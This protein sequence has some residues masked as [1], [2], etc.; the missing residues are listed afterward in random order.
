LE[1]EDGKIVIG[2]KSSDPTVWLDRLATIFRYIRYV[3]VTLTSSGSSPLRNW[4]CNAPKSL[5]SSRLPNAHP[6]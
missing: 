5:W 4:G 3:T 1:T 6:Y 2:S